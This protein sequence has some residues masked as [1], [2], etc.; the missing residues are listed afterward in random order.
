[1]EDSKNKSEEMNYRNESLRIFNQI[2]KETNAIYHNYAA[3]NGMSDTQFWIMYFICYYGEGITQKDICEECFYT[4]QTV[5]SS[6]KELERKGILRLE[7][8]PGSKKV[9]QMFLTSEGKQMAQRIAV[10][11][12]E[13]EKKSFEALNKE[14]MKAMFDISIK[15]L[16]KLEE[17]VEKIKEK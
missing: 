12:I 10:P 7:L 8:A 9:K 3:A 2:W 11:V 15:H 16:K 4:A 6:I 13:A 14:E 17:F 5:N 1:M